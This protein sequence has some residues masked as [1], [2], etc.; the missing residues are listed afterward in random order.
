MGRGSEST[1]SGANGFKGGG[2]NKDYFVDPKLVYRV[3]QFVEEQRERSSAPVTEDSAMRYLLEKFK[4]YVRKPQVRST[5]ESRRT[6][7]Y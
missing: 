5:E 6:I 2:E 3:K 4:E 1:G 7:A